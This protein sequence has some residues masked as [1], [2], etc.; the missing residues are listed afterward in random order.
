MNKKLKFVLES[1]TEPWC[2]DFMTKLEQP[3]I[4][5]FKGIKDAQLA[6]C[7]LWRQHS[8][9]YQLSQA[10][11]TSIDGART[12]HSQ[13][14]SE[15]SAY[16]RRSRVQATSACTT[17]WALRPQVAEINRRKTRAF[18]Q[19]H[20]QKNQDLLKDRVGGDY[21]FPDRVADMATDAILAFLDQA[22]WERDEQP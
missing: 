15:E 7:E 6:A 9:G 2:E 12:Y 17:M 5:A 19:Q 21:D 11:V 18:L 13:P 10:T 16:Q 14:Q 22:L 3:G 1:R 20:L 8:G 4:D